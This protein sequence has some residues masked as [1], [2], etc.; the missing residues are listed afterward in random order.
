MARTGAVREHEE[1]IELA[2]PLGRI[3]RG[4]DGCVGISRKLEGNRT[5]QPL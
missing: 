5:H 4:G 1:G 2:I 3:Q